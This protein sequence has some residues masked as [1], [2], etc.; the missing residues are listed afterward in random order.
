MCGSFGIYNTWT[1][2]CV[3]LV[4]NREK[5]VE[6][7]NANGWQLDDITSYETFILVDAGENK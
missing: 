5:A 3:A 2:H 6:L 4:E 7:A 1:A